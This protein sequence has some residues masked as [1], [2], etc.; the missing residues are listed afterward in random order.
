M[1]CMTLCWRVIIVDV[2][3]HKGRC[4]CSL[5]MAGLESRKFKKYNSFRRKGRFIATVVSENLKYR[6]N[7]VEK[8]PK[9]QA[10]H[11]TQF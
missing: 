7:R 9:H 10:F 3:Q 5:V 11:N 6:I 1:E 4:G 2:G 8:I